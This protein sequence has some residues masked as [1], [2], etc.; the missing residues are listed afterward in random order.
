MWHDGFLYKL[1]PHRAISLFA[2]LLESTHAILCHC[3]GYLYRRCCHRRPR[4]SSFHFPERHHGLRSIKLTLL[5]IFLYQV[6]SG[7][8][9][10]RNPQSGEYH[11]GVCIDPIVS[12]NLLIPLLQDSGGMGGYPGNL[13]NYGKGTQPP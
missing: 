5:W 10:E 13:P 9:V 2:R 11:E 4:T 7:E 1:P 8:L 3:R 12:H 6:F